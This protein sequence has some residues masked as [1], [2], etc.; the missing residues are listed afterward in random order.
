MTETTEEV[1]R[2]AFGDVWPPRNTWLMDGWLFRQ[3]APDIVEAWNDAIRK[4][5]MTVETGGDD[6]YT[7]LTGSLTREGAIA[8]GILKE[9]T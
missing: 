1:L 5:W 7:S 2:R 6:Q 8:I 3:T 9:E 4:G